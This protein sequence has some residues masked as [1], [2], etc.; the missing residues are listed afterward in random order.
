MA[1]GDR[2]TA[3]AKAMLG[4]SWPRHRSRQRAGRHP[5]PWGTKAREPLLSRDNRLRL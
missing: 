5:A 1:P 3:T 2:Q 4:Q